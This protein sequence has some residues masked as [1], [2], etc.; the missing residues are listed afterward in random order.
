MSDLGD[1]IKDAHNDVGSSFSIIRSG[2]EELSGEYCIFKTNKQVT[3][4]FI[5]EFFQDGS[6]DYDTDI[7]AGDVVQSSDGRHLMIMNLTPTVFQD[8]IIENSAVLYKC[9]VSGE[10]LRPSEEEGWDDD[11]R[12]QGGFSVQAVDVFA[13]QT[14]ALY[15]H[16]LDSDDELGSLGLE[17][18]E[19][20]VPGSFDVQVL[21]RYQPVSGEYFQVETIKKRRFDN[22]WVCQI[23]EDT[24]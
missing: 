21:D 18:H 23:T 3:K 20:Y 10:L 11:Y 15:G 19:L 6:F 8:E 5:R 2:E 14:E 9:N 1:D 24:R 16:E 17:E 12:M 7:I 13:L 4:P 22:V